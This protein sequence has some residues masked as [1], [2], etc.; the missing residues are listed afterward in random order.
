LYC[1][2]NIR[3]IHKEHEMGRTSGTYATYT[4]YLTGFWWGNLKERGEMEWLD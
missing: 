1:P 3:V 4:K 2:P